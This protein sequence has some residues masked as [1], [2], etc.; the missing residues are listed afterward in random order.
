MNDKFLEVAAHEEWLR[1]QRNTLPLSR[2]TDGSIRPPEPLYEGLLLHETLTMVSG[3][4]YTGKTLF[5]LATALSLASGKPLFGVYHPKE[6][7]RVLFIGQDAPTW[8][9]AGQALKLARGYGIG[10]DDLR[11]YE[12]DLILNEGV[13]ITEPS[14]LD[15]LKQWHDA[16]GFD[17]LMLDTLLDVHNADENSNSQMRIV[18]KLL[19]SIRDTF[20]CAILF[21]HHTSKPQL[22]DTR[23]ANYMSRGATVIPGS[24]D[25]HF[26]LRAGREHVDMLWPKGRGATG[27]DPPPS[28]VIAESVVDG[29]PA[30]QLQVSTE[31]DRVELIKTELIEPSTRS[32]LIAKVLGA[33][34]G[35]GPQRAAKWVDNQLQAL[36]RNGLVEQE[37]RGKW[38]LL[39]S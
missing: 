16:T 23:S 29:Q 21:S 36:K 20:G 24:S 27:M 13:I 5:L 39:P 1:A 19:K 12:V 26:Q 34:P 14:F 10:A 9:Y 6:L 25:F 33:E 35:L 11:H 37:S 8:D 4:P 17:V 28:F 3:E 22:G 15:W 7:R 2:L 38:K 32:A 18:M 31:G 30:I